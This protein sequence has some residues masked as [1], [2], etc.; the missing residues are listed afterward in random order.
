MLDFLKNKKETET[1][2]EN[3]QNDST[4]TNIELRD[5]WVKVY[6]K[7]LEKYPNIKCWLDFKST[8]LI[9]QFDDYLSPRLSPKK[10]QD[11]EDYIEEVTGMAESI[12]NQIMENLESFKEFIKDPSPRFVTVDAIPGVGMPEREYPYLLYATD[13]TVKELDSE[14]HEEVL[15]FYGTDGLHSG[16][17][18]VFVFPTCQVIRNMTREE[19][20]KFLG[21]KLSSLNLTPWDF[22]EYKKKWIKLYED[23]TEP[24]AKN[25]KIL[26]GV[27][28]EY[29]IIEHFHET[30]E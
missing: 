6:T 20:D 18:L 1:K 24:Q 19:F 5:K 7:T 10:H 15:K 28:G 9:K 12:N 13:F 27:R 29:G 3:G 16:F 17:K 23:T 14:Y 21:K 8:G 26:K 25:N 22:D 4:P 30:K 11:I 2:V